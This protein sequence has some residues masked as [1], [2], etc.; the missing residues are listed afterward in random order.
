MTY[1][2]LETGVTDWLRVYSNVLDDTH[3]LSLDLS[4]SLSFSPSLC[5]VFR[6]FFFFFQFIIIII[7]LLHSKAQ[8]VLYASTKNAW[9]V[10]QLWCT[11]YPDW[12][13]LLYVDTLR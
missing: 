2:K 9:G 7:K 10:M 11:L 13:V 3:T 6:C 5:M 1:I 12:R 4:E 8:H